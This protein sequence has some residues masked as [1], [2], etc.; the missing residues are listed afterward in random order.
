MIGSAQSQMD[1][2][3]EEYASINNRYASLAAFKS[4][5]PSFIG[6]VVVAGITLISFKYFNTSSAVL[7]SF[8]FLFTRAGTNFSEINSSFVDFKFNSPSVDKLI[9][10]MNKIDAHDRNSNAVDEIKQT[11]DW[12]FDSLALQNVDFGYSTEEMVFQDLSFDFRRGEILLIKGESGVGKSTLISLIL[13]I[14]DPKSGLIK[15]NGK[16]D[17]QLLEKISSVVGYVGPEPYLINGT[18]KDNLLYGLPKKNASQISDKVIWDCLEM[19]QIQS[20]VFNFNNKLGEIL[21]EHVQISSGQKQRLS[22]ARAFLRNPQVLVFDEATANLDKVTEEKIINQ[23]I[24]LS[25]LGTAI[26]LISHKE[27]F[28]KIA[29]KVINMEKGLQPVFESNPNKKNIQI[30]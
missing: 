9:N 3:L 24:K 17:R 30:H 11:S 8:F 14:N 5:L 28:D 19:A 12:S 20:L 23:L 22:I 15:L 6:T 13:G 25:K 1:M 10:I 2:H 26:V 18:V 27:S 7:L 29:D 16:E 4:S 21:N